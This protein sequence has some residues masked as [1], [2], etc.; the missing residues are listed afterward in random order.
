LKQHPDYFRKAPE[1][2]IALILFYPPTNHLGYFVPGRPGD[3]GTDSEII[4]VKQSKDPNNPTQLIR[5][6]APFKLPRNPT[7]PDAPRFI[8]GAYMTL[9]DW[10]EGPGGGATGVFNLLY[11]SPPQVNVNAVF[12]FSGKF[13]ADACPT[14]DGTLLP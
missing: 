3:E 13:K 8:D 12:P 10:S 5:V 9:G 11:A 7:S 1:D 2:Y 6:V 4:G 14:L